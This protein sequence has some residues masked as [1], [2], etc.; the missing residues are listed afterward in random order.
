MGKIEKI[1]AK[2]KKY[3]DGIFK[4]VESYSFLDGNLFFVNYEDAKEKVP[5]KELQA[6]RNNLLFLSANA[7]NI[8]E[9]GFNA[10][11]SCLLMLLANKFSKITIIDT[12]QHKY[13]EK[14]F[15]YLNKEFPQRIKLI[16][17]D[18]TK[19]LKGFKKKEFNLIHYDGGKEKTIYNDIM[20]TRSLV[21]DDHVLVI[22]DYQNEALKKIVDQLESFLV[23]DTATYRNLS[24][25]SYNFKWKHTIAKFVNNNLTNEVLEKLQVIYDNDNFQSIYS[26]AKDVF[27]IIGYSRADSLVNI[28]RA[29]QNID[30]AF[31]ECG[32]AAG[33]SS[34]IAGIA[35]KSLNIDKSFYLY[36]TF[37][38]FN[39]DLDEELDFEGNS[40]ADYDLSKYKSIQTSV[41]EVEKKLLMSGIEKKNIV[42][43]K[44]MVENTIPTQMPDK[45]SVIRLD[46]DLYKPTL[47]CL[48]HMFSKLEEN[49]YLIIDDYGHWQGCKQ[50][51]DEFFNQEQ[52]DLNDL[53]YI[54]YTC[55][56]Y[57]RQGNKRI[58]DLLGN[59]GGEW[60]EE[61]HNSLYPLNFNKGL[62][63]YIS[64]TINPK[65]FLEFGSGLGLLAD[66]LCK[67]S[68][69]EVGYC[70]EP[71]PIKSIYNDSCPKLMVLDI[72]KEKAQEE[73]NR[74][75]DVVISIEVA[76]HIPIDNHDYLFDF[77][78]AHTKKWIIF[79]GGRIGQ[80][81]HGHI[82]ER[83]E[84]D[85]KSEFIKRGMK[86]EQEK[87]EAVRRE[88][89]DR[90]INHKKNLLIFSREVETYKG[91][92][93]E[94]E[95]KTF[96]SK[97]LPI[98][99]SAIYKDTNIQL[100]VELQKKCDSSW[101]E[102]DSFWKERDSLQKKLELKNELLQQHKEKVNN[103]S[104]ELL[105][106][107]NNKVYKLLNALGLFK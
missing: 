4:I 78:V 47:H 53:I 16:K 50:A 28:I 96:S 81:G 103:L 88:S 107:R 52:L 15:E 30:G 43:V 105:S 24:E 102:C 36:D 71:Q 85:W 70:I 60:N 68:N 55:R 94:D 61:T 95:I 104:R 40:I 76:E 59:Y 74:R 12:C 48:K 56:I 29:T 1:E 18:S 26:N 80:T 34:A 69:T 49:G 45:I 97:Y 72:F 90:N 17:G 6:K 98:N 39:F 25:K 75:V 91:L 101:K 106:L 33:H 86:F 66:A 27:K 57:K 13:T 77:L 31:V 7:G 41:E 37:E 11:H 19:N 65:S 64:K 44:G 35:M 79:S 62:S 8:L 87:T 23:L 58:N 32:V 67:N 54:D 89:D 84:E 3:L 21:S 46:M 38:G 83:I 2:A 42:M 22:D 99:N 14:C 5:N 51:V 20:N 10:G 63:S 92:S 9:I 73:I 93:V 100:R 82:A